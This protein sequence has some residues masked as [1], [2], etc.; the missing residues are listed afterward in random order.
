MGAWRGVG[1]GGFPPLDPR[2]TL[3][4]QIYDVVNI[5]NH[6]IFSCLF[7]CCV[8]VCRVRGQNFS[9]KLLGCKCL[10]QNLYLLTPCLTWDSAVHCPR[11]D[12]SSPLGAP[13]SWEM[14]IGT[15][16]CLCSL[17]T[18]HG[19]LSLPWVYGHQQIIR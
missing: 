14:S 7:V 18:F 19:F 6:I 4:S 2:P 15:G 5:F 12:T 11:L 17:D 3:N 13:V 10:L 1:G 9:H 16:P 8:F